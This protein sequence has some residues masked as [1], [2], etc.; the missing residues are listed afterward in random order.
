MQTGTIRQDRTRSEQNNSPEPGKIKDLNR[1]LLCQVQA[2]SPNAAT[3]EGLKTPKGPCWMYEQSQQIILGFEV[4]AKPSL[5]VGF[6]LDREKLGSLGMNTVIEN[7]QSDP[8]KQVG[9]QLRLLQLLLLKY[10]YLV[11]A[12]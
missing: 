11:C 10:V 9:S 5:E 7:E 6:F 8:E 4:R 2:D 12:S 1:I 3:M